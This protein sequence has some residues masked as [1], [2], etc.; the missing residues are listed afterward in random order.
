VDGYKVS[1]EEQVF[2]P[3]NELSHVLQNSVFAEVFEHGALVLGKYK[4]LFYGLF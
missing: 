2:N 4:S 3:E 1:D